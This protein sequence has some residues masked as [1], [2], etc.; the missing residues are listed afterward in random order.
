MNAEVSAFSTVDYRALL[1][2][3]LKVIKIPFIFEKELKLDASSDHL[4][5]FS[6]V[7]LS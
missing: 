1:Q 4:C 7:L 6:L 2:L 5:R 3:E